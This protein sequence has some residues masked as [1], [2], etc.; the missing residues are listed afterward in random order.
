MYKDASYKYIQSNSDI[1]MYNDANSLYKQEKFDES[2]KKY[3]LIS[4]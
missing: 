3:Q 2:I 1:G 4:T